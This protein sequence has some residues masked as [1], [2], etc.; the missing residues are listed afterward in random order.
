MD[1]QRILKEAQKIAAKFS[2]WMVSGNI[3]HLYGYPYETPEKKFDLE[4]KFK[5]DFP[6]SPPIFIY[7]NNIKELLGD[8]LLNSLKTWN[9]ESS[10][11]DIVNELKLKIQNALQEPPS[12]GKKVQFEPIMTSL[13]NDIYEKAQK[14]ISS[15]DEY[16]TPDLDVYPPDFNINDVKTQIDSDVDLTYA[17]ESDTSPT[18]TSDF[19]ELENEEIIEQTEQLSI[20]VNTELSLIQQYYT[21]D[22]K[23]ISQVD[24]NVYMTITISSTFII[25]ISFI[26]Y[27]KKPKITFPEEINNILGD[28]YKSLETLKKWNPKKPPHIIDVLQELEN[29]LFFLKDIEMESKKILGEYKCDVIGSSATKLKVHLLTYGFKEYILDIDLSPYPRHPKINLDAQLQQIIS[30]PTKSLKAY[31]NWE[32]K[33]SEPIE[34]IREISWLVDKN[35]RINFEIDLLK[36]DYEN[37]KYDPLTEILNL[38]MKGKMKTQDLIFKFQINLPREYPMKVPDIKVLNE[39]EL[40]SHEKLKDDLQTSFKDFF[41]KWT[42]FSYLVDLFNL[43]SEKIFEVSV[44]A[45]VICHNIQCPT[46]SMKI[47]GS[48]SCNTACPHC[49]RVYHNHCWE[50][51]ITQFGKCGFCLRVP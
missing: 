35:S 51:T 30:E 26:D 44:V 43:I 27:P 15:S 31:I 17:D 39:F 45:C 40:E 14:E 50:Q 47:A 25:G 19:H 42:P 46:C 32:E 49:E 24:I 23:G 37:I 5:E 9:Q 48:E 41:N 13:D 36:K 28:P 2:F 1:K 7:H 4:I 18:A 11:V 10:V 6:L 21:Y 22:Q 16:I 3:T 38:D 8:I 33:K 20:D 29:K 12:V 34:I